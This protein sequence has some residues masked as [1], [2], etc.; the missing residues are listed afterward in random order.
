[1]AM[2]NASELNFEDIRVIFCVQGYSINNNYVVREI[3]FWSRG[4]SGVI[5]FTSRNKFNKL[6]NEDKM[7]VNYLV[8]AHHGIPLNKQI[9]YGLMN[10]EAVAAIKTLYH[11]FSNDDGGRKRNYIGICDDLNIFH[12]LNIAGL[13]HL[14][15][16]LKKLYH[17]PEA[18]IPSN[19][20]ILKIEEFG[21]C[22]L[23]PCELHNPLSNEKIPFCARTKAIILANWCKSINNSINKLN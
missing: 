10:H 4:N 7:T 6:S 12:L 8:K 1:M 17:K 19:D 13:G 16:N 3:G 23:R 21:Y 5:P 18:T 11:T 9:N 20:N 2:L 14:V 22:C 15:I